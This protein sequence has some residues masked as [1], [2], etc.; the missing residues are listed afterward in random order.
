MKF[1]TKEECCIWLSNNLDKKLVYNGDPSHHLEYDARNPSPFR[2]VSGNYN[3]KLG[4]GGWSYEFEVVDKLDTIYYKNNGKYDTEIKTISFE[5]YKECTEWLDS[6]QDKIL[7]YD[8]KEESYYLCY[9]ASYNLKRYRFVG[10]KLTCAMDYAWSDEY[11]IL[12]SFD[13]I[14]NKNFID[15]TQLCKTEEGKVYSDE[16]YPTSIENL[17]FWQAFTYLRT[18]KY[19]IK[20]E[21]DNWIEDVYF[22]S[23]LGYYK[24]KFFLKYKENNNLE[25]LY[26]IEDNEIEYEDLIAN[27]WIAILKEEI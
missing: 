21:N 6:N 17:N 27:D 25:K 9:N 4:G 14:P 8:K 12:N 10:L 15:Y 20:R 2:Y 13:E 5:S 7:Y 19:V 26:I 18:N 23:G 3:E 24:D 1:K 11:I 22:I 16:Q